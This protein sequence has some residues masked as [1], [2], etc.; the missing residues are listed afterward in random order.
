MGV[1]IKLLKF[2]IEESGMSLP[3]VAER[4]DINL[5]TFYRKLDGKGEFKASEIVGLTKAL[6]L[7][8]SEQK[9]IF[10]R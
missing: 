2:K 3:V 1:N 5:Q 10:L 4:A 9:D 8:S 7:K 6:K